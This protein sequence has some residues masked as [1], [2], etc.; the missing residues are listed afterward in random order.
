MKKTQAILEFFREKHT[1]YPSGFI[2]EL[3]YECE[4]MA[5]EKV[6]EHGVDVPDKIPDRAILTSGGFWK[7]M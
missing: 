7:W 4:G 2:G 3:I 1:L 6:R 5:A